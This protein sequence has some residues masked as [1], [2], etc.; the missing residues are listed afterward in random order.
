MMDESAPAP[1]PLPGDV[2]SRSTLKTI[3]GIAL[4]V[5]ALLAGV[6]IVWAWLADFAIPLRRVV[7]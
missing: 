6:F 5:V 1:E 4:F 2:I 7:S 3:G